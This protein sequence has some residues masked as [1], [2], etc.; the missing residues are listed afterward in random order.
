MKL[1]S[2]K[3]SVKLK[4]SKESVKLKSSKESV[5]LKS[6]QESVK[7]K[8]SQESVKFCKM[9]LQTVKQF[10][11]YVQQISVIIRFSGRVSCLFAYGLPAKKMSQ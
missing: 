2:S 3:E 1:K 8:S 11:I 9:V 5:K 7:L 6:S 4:S 10:F